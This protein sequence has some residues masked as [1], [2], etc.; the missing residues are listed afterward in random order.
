MK[1]SASPKKQHAPTSSLSRKRGAERRALIRKNHSSGGSILLRLPLPDATLIQPIN[2]TSIAVFAAAMFAAF[3]VVFSRLNCFHV[4]YGLGGSLTD[5]EA[6]G[7]E[8]GKGYVDYHFT[9]R[10]KVLYDEEARG[11]LRANPG[12]NLGELDLGFVFDADQFGAH[13]LS[14]GKD[15]KGSTKGTVGKPSDDAL[16]YITGERIR[17]ALRKME[18]QM[19]RPGV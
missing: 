9:G 11:I 15:G 4:H 14:L 13:P 16:F 17:N 6:I 18:E 19:P 2:P 3:I 1:M 10:G 7:S 8:K 5:L 12:I